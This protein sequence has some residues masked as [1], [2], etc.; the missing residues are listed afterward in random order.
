VADPFEL[1]QLELRRSVLVQRLAAAEELAAEREQRIEDLR[2]AL[3]T[4][5]KVRAGTQVMANGNAPIQPG[6]DPRAGAAQ[7][8][9]KP[10]PTRGT[11]Q[12]GATPFSREL[13]RRG[14]PLENWYETFEGFP[15]PRRRPTLRWPARRLRRD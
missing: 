4:I 15:R 8:P 3:V 7:M 9:G 11:L 2:L 10:R 1:E 14:K 6:S 13:A 5:P 12:N